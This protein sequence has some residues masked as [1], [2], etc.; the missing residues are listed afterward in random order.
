MMNNLELHLKLE[1][2]IK[3]KFPER[4]RKEV[5]N[6]EN[7]IHNMISSQLEANSSRL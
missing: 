1:Q 3:E 4:F 7:K 2:L 5:F 6:L